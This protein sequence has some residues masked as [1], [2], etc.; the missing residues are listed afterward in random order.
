MELVD[1]VRQE[2]LALPNE[3]SRIR[4]KDLVEKM[5]VSRTPIRDALKQLEIE[6]LIE[7][8]KNRGITLRQHSPKE[9]ADLY[10]IRAVLE[11]LA[12]REAAQFATD[13]DC[14]QL[15]KISRQ[16]TSEKD[17]RKKCELDNKFHNCV[18]AISNNQQL[19]EL[20]G[21]YLILHRL[22]SMIFKLRK[23]RR[24]SVKKTPFGHDKIIAALRENDS[25]LTEELLKNH[26]LWAKNRILEIST[27]IEID[28]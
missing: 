15:E 8:R 27:G 28:R 7:R 6:Q 13:E 23:A 20:I 3:H 22:F 4:E 2:V 1:L 5:G 21:R 11:G 10:N 18:I 12:G 16:Y 14:D 25:D 19:E 24:T 17:H 9:I 26:C